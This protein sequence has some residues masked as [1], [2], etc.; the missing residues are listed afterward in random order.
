MLVLDMLCEFEGEM[1]EFVGDYVTTG[2]EFP[3]G[4][5]LYGVVCDYI[6]WFEANAGAAARIKKLELHFERKA[7]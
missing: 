3:Q 5:A 6:G 1:L 4:I 2:H 7:C